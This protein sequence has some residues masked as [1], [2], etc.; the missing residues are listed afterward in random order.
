MV[1][2]FLGFWYSSVVCMQAVYSYSL[3]LTGFIRFHWGIRLI[4]VT[5]LKEKRLNIIKYRRN[6]YRNGLYIILINY[7]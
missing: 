2:V 6:S 3:K 1:S 7:L 4:E 5:T